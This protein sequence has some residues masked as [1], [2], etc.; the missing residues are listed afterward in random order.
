MTDL[1]DRYPNASEGELYFLS[2]VKTG[3]M[4][5]D[6]QGQIWRRAEFRSEGYL[7]LKKSPGK[8]VNR[9]LCA[10]AHRLVH[11]HFHGDIGKGLEINH[12]NAKRDDNRPENLEAVT[13]DENMKHAARL[14]L[15]KSRKGSTNHNAKLNETA[16]TEMRLLREQGLSYQIIARQFGVSKRAA[17]LAITRKTW[18]HVP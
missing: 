9:W 4:M 14:G 6:K 17:I 16:V 12:K 5:I 13:H 2:K 1:K 15:I 10:Q 11:L 7:T 8:E 3:H 18:R